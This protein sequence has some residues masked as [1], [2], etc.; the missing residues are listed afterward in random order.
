MV[1]ASPHAGHAGSRRS[2]SVRKL[3]CSASKSSPGLVTQMTSAGTAAAVSRSA[4]SSVSGISAP[5]AAI[6]TTERSVRRSG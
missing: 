5:I 2:F 1:G 3:I 6:V 4:A